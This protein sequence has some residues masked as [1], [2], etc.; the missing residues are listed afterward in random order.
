MASGPYHQALTMKALVFHGPHQLR[1]EDWPLAAPAAGEAVMA[2]R[3]VGI[4]GSDVH[5]FTGESGRRIPPMVMGHEAAGEVVDLGPGVAR[6][7]LGQRVILQ[8]FVWCGECDMC[9]S[10][11]INLCRNRRFFGATIHG[12][13]AERLI[14]PVRNLVPMPETLSFAHGALTEPLSVAMHAVH[15]AGNLQGAAVLIAGC[16]PIGLLTLIAAQRAGAG[17]VVATDVIPAR[18][19]A[20][21]D[22]GAQAALDPRDEDWRAQAAEV[23]GLMLGEFDIAFDAVGITATFQQA[24]QAVRPGGTVVA[25]GGWQTVPVNLG[26]LVAREITVRGTFNFTPP[27]FD[28]AC[29]VLASEDATPLDH[30]VTGQHPLMDGADVF[31]QL[32]SHPSDAIKVVLT[33]TA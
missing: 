29:R 13:M 27:E 14:V 19:A 32:A 8:P 24:I 12:A 7:W 15:Q 26:P 17:C 30:F 33:H 2:V 4:C 28:A 18:L 31:N 22:L 16:G 11:R 10:G 1:W 3:A 6:E 20:A 5:G 9:R 23:A 25:L 21:R